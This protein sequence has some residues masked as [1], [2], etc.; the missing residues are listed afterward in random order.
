M[1]FPPIL[2]S[3][4]TLWEILPA[5]VN[6]LCVVIVSFSC[7]P[8]LFNASLQDLPHSQPYYHPTPYY[9]RDYPL[10]VDPYAHPALSHADAFPHRHGPPL[11]PRLLEYYRRE[12]KFP[13]RS[14]EHVDPRRLELRSERI[15]HREHE[16]SRERISEDR[17]ERPRDDSF[18]KRLEERGILS[19]V[20]EETRRTPTACAAGMNF[21]IYDKMNSYLS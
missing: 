9:G 13:E 20:K 2:W 7:Q 3:V 21:G 12:H 10:P 16:N 1:N 18:I 8:V 11:S 4:W 17:G 6:I 14:R 15:E 19:T 5:K